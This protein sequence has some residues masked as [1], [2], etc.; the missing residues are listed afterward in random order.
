MTARVAEAANL[1]DPDLPRLILRLALPAIA[2]LSINAMHHLLNIFWLGRL[3]AEAVSAVSGVLPLLIL[4]GAVGEAIGVGTG[5]YVS[6]LLGAGRGEEASRTATVGMAIAIGAGIAV[7]LGVGFH[8]DSALSSTGVTEAA[9]PLAR[10]YMAIVLVSYTL[11]L[12]QIFGDFLAISEG[13]ARFSMAVLIGSFTLNMILDPLLI[14]GFGL[15][16]KGAALATL[17]AQVAAVA[18]YGIYFG[19]RLGVVSIAARHFRPSWAIIREILAVGGPAAL[20][21]ALMAL[22]FALVYATAA[23]YGDAAVAGMGVALRLFNAGA[24]P[25]FGFCL[26]A[27]PVIGFAWGAG[28]RARV[29]AG[30]RFMLMLT[31]GFCAI[32]GVAMLCFSSPIMAYFAR[33]AATHEAGSSAMVA[34]FALFPLF[35]LQCVLISFLQAC[36]KVRLALL[37]L[38]APQGYFLI[39][40]VLV[41][42]GLWGF[43]GLLAAPVIS[44]ALTAMMAALLLAQQAGELRRT[45]HAA[46]QTVSAGL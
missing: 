2:G 43:S 24:L 12:L 22:A 7:S 30:L 29:L 11:L 37:V 32:Y 28:D 14:F 4:L 10:S 13:N 26:G 40:G 23:Q 3:G 19:A 44:A 45:A 9:F 21:S 33:D 16:I 35:G 39:P 1:G 27:R 31:T 6:R 36:G 38:L 41:L 25:V 15:G 46:P 8:L 34:I 5:S 20:A 17:S 42:P 18:A